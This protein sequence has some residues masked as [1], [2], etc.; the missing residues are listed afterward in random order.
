MASARLAA[1]ARRLI[2]HTRSGVLATTLP[3]EESRPATPFASLVS[4]AAA[5]DLAPVL[6]LSALA[7]HSRNLARDPRCSVLLAG[8]PVGPN[9]QTAPRVT[10]IGA[11]AR[12]DDAAL[13]ARWH[14]LN[15]HAALYA[16][17]TDFSLWR[18]TIEAV[19]AVAGFAAAARLDPALVLPDPAIASRLAAAEPGILAHCNEHHAPAMDAIAAGAGASG[20]GWRLAALDPDGCD[21]ARGE[22][23]LRIDFAAPAQTPDAVR[24]ELVRLAR[25]ARA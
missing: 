11:A 6:W 3:A 8:P 5:P 24:A 4:L 19:H 15:P 22:D 13:L 17:L 18:L 9:P 10:L 25:A 7:Q 12:I 2:R 20:S 21:L 23:L 14:A 16:G 1:I